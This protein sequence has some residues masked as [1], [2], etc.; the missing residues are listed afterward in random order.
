MALYK[1]I[2]PKAFA[3]LLQKETARRVIPVDSTWYLPAW[4]R[5]SKKE[6]LEAERIPNAVYFDIDAIKDTKSPYP[7]MAPDLPTFNNAM[8]Q[9]GLRR[10]DILVVYDTIG[11]FSAPR[12]AW[13]L[14]MFGH[15]PV[16]LLNNYPI[17]KQAGYPL[18]TTRK[19]SFTP[20]SQTEYNSATNLCPENTV[21]YD[22]I[23]ELVK[24]NE[25]SKK[26]NVFD[27]RSLARFEGRAP[28]PRP[29]LPSGHIPG[30]QPLPYT[31]VLDPETKAYPS[32]P[33]DMEAK[34]HAA[35]KR[36]NDTFDSTKPTIAMCGTGVSGCIIKK[37]LELAGVKNVKL[38]DG[39]WTE[40]A[41]RSTDPQWLAKGRD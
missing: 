5:D 32:D 14:T 2:S 28:E 34:L 6:F 35:F 13:T 4:N 38:Y 25:L 24:R 33:A 30:T 37:A 41:L 29:G 3:E 19:E 20:Y 7:H 21:G 22:E 18:E 1:L 40:W 15:E 8:S 27:A 10:D 16:Y 17:Y 39:S 26:Y 12:C 31:E 9:L 23:L 11:N 36:L